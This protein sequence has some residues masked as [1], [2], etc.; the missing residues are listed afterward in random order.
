MSNRSGGKLG[1]DAGPRF[2]STNGAAMAMA[3]VSGIM[4]G[5]TG[6][7]SASEPH[8]AMKALESSP[9][10]DLEGDREEMSAELT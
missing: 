1:T 2:T 8:E 4:P 10:A 5:S 9:V 6:K 7:G 3:D